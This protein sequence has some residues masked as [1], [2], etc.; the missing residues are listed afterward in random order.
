MLHVLALRSVDILNFTTTFLLKHLDL[1][2]TDWPAASTFANLKTS[3]WFVFV[4][5]KLQH[6]ALINY[7][8][9]NIQCDY[10]SV[11]C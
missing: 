7:C 6:A 3:E 8:E 9:A 10:Q 1:T 5:F 2:V 4:F 11:T